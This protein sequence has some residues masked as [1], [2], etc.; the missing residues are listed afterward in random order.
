MKIPCSVPILTL[1]VCE[2]LRETLPTLT[3]TFDD[4]FLVDGNSTDG[5]QAYARSLGVRVEK[6]VDTDEPNQRITDFPKARMESWKKCRYDWVLV[7]DADEI[8]TP[9]LVGEIRQIIERDNRQ[10][11]HWIRR[12]PVLPSGQ[13]IKNSPFYNTPYCRLFARSSGVRI[14][15]QLV[16]EKFLIPDTVRT[17]WHKEA[18]LCPEPSPQ[19]LR[20]R[21]KRYALLEGKSLKNARITLL[22]RWIIW[23]NLRS[24]F[25]QC[26]RVIRSEIVA[27]WREE[28]V[29]PWSYTRVFLLY[30]WWSLREGVR[31]WLHLYFAS[32]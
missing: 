29:L 26:L 8:V 25:G 21:A 2:R 5:T 10:E 22:V 32:S 14:A 20:E 15:D 6:Q 7:L 3:E 28:P 24:F 11:V 23:Y 16:H 1:N 18:I 17:V 31:A 27:W 9:E 30:R 13:V 12:Y 4:V 19:A